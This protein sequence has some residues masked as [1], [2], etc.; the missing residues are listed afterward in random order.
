MNK[1][2]KVKKY[3]TYDPYH[4]IH[5]KHCNGAPLLVMKDFIPYNT[6]VVFFQKKYP[7]IRNNKKAKGGSRHKN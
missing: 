5:K 6:A 3:I 1:R 2:K 4:V 7:K